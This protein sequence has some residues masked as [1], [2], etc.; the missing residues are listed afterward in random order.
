MSVGFVGGPAD[1][2]SFPLK[3]APFYLRVVVDPIGTVAPIDGLP[4]PAPQ[5]DEG[6]AV[7]VRPG[8]VLQTL[9]PAGWERTAIYVHLEDLGVD[10]DELRDTAA[11]RAWAAA[12]PPAGEGRV[13]E[14]RW[15]VPAATS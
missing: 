12:Q 4:A 9:G 15:P 3:R 11:W 1:G 13:G 2:L 7:Y 10:V 6:L 8:E 14:T 5:P